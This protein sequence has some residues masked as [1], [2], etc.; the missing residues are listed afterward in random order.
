M[1]HEKIEKVE[2]NFKSNLKELKKGLENYF[3]QIESLANSFGYPSVYFHH[4]ALREMEKNFLEFPHIEAIYA[5]LPAWGMQ[6]KTKI[7]AFEKFKGQIEEQKSK[8]VE[9]R[10]KKL[11]EVSIDELSELLVSSR[12]SEAASRLVSSSK[13]LHHIIPN[14][15]C[16]I[17]R[18][19]SIRFLLQDKNDFHKSAYVYIN[20]DERDYA[21]IYLSGMRDFIEDNKVVLEKHID[22]SSNTSLTKIF[23][24]LVMV[25]VRSVKSKKAEL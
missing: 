5:L 23:D 21:K 18:Q 1:T 4:R 7:A 6:S 15:I 14:L 20:E 19:Y 13:V 3:P 12:F 24:N 11:S 16:P 2:K 22:G 8:L 17:D 25:F 10:S 9:L